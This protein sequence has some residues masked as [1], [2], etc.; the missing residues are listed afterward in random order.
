MKKPLSEKAL[1]KE[2]AFWT[3][4]RKAMGDPGAFCRK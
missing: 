3:G 2:T 4:M 1:A